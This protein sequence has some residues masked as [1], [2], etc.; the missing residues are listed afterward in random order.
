M[1]RPLRWIWGLIPVAF[2]AAMAYFFVTPQIELELELRTAQALARANHSWAEVR[3]EGRDI[4]LRGTAPSEAALR[5][6]LDAAASA[7]GVRRVSHNVIVRVA[8][9]N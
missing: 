1:C 7:E 3:V 5:E 9:V 6:A 4:T 2:L 8:P